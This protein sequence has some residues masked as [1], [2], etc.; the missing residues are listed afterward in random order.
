MRLTERVI[1]EGR[2][3]CL[4]VSALHWCTMHEPR[5]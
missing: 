4:S 5:L 2:S 3:V 1:N